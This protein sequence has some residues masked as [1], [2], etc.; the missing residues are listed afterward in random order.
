MREERGAR[1]DKDLNFERS[2]RHGKADE[3]NV[4]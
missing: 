2:T 4:G 3:G 1:S